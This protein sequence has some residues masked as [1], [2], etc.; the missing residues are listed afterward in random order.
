MSN[1]EKQLLEN[2]S[3]EVRF[4]EISR[5]V[6]SVDASIY[7]I[8]PIGIVL[9]KTESD[10]L[11]TIRIAKQHGIPIIARGA[12]T[13]ITGGCIG[14]GLIIDLSKYMN[15][16]LEINEE[17]GYAI[18]QPG[19]VQDRLNEALAPRGYRLGPDTSTGNRATLGGMAGNNAAGA[20]SLR[21]GK[22]VDHVQEVKLALASG[23]LITFGCLD[24][25]QWQQKAQ[26]QSEEGN[27]YRAL[28]H[29]R[30]EYAEDIRTRFPHIPRRVS[31]YNLDT[32]LHPDIIN[33]SQL[34]VG[35]EGSLGIISEMKVRICKRPIH[36]G[37]CLMHCHDMIQAMAAIPQMLSQNPLAIE[38]IDH[39]II[40]M[41]AQSPAMKGKLDW[42]MGRP[43]AIFAAEFEGETPQEV[44]EKLEQFKSMVEKAS[45]ADHIA[46]ITDSN[47]MNHVWDIRK[48]GLGLLL[49]KRDYSRAIAFVE[50]L[51]VAPEQLAPF[52]KEFN[53][54][55]AKINKS[56]GIYGH[57]GSGCMHLRP[58]IDL[59][60]PEE[61]A[62]MLRMMNEISDLVLKYGGALSGEH[63]DGHLR[64]WLN[65]KM[66]GKRLYQAFLE[67]KHAFDPADLM[68]PGKVVNGQAFL[69]NLRLSPD[70]VTTEFQTFQDFTPEGGFELAVD[71]CNGNGLC[72]KMEGTMCPSFQATGDEFHSTRARAQT[73]R[74]LIHGRLKMK[75]MAQQGIYDVLD[76]CLQCKA[77]KT[78]CPSQVDMAKMKAE[79]LF[80]YQEK[81]GYTLRNRIFAHIGTLNA[82]MSPFAKFF[83]HSMQ[84]SVVQWLFKKMGISTQHPLPALS[85]E[86]FSEWMSKI[87]LH[88]EGKKV[89]L[90]NDTYTE[91]YHPEIGQAAYRV[92]SA[93]GYQVIVPSWKCCGRTLISKGFLKQA[94]K[95]ALAVFNQLLPYVE[96]GIP[97]VGLEPSCIL[98]LKDDFKGLLPNHEIDKLIALTSTFDEFV[99]AHITD[100]KLPLA[101]KNIEAAVKVHGHCHQ[102]ALVGMAPTLEVLKSIATLKVEEIHSGCCGMAGSFGYEQEHEVIS[103]KIGELVLLPAVRATPKDTIIIANGMSCRS[104]IQHG[105]SRHALHVAQLLD[106]LRKVD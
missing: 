10:L 18:C 38:M 97:I 43:Q 75:E 64:T 47:L 41:G 50:D 48:A 16:I 87:P 12:A 80:H 15:R 71:L 54:Y 72:R 40:E 102:K 36:T 93:L 73:L 44:T 32:L 19:V 92:L 56:A 53:D 76:L 31:G 42:L 29:I 34:I 51:T 103:Q 7:E 13:G 46:L 99:H 98:T 84:W 60:K 94:K 45:F 61:T 30:T 86:R 74:D 81:Y 49:S 68:N 21:Y 55:L 22:M 69:D 33:V 83:N 3:G 63:G 28:M 95:K 25:H 27:I 14:K 26:E 91:F 37:I 57:V 11:N 9:P 52:M 6:Y 82:M 101:F 58:Y 89:V 85:P 20:R 100:G 17:R 2:I 23:N 4:D 96:E 35:A 70:T 77:C 5:K 67:V 90:F 79:F 88:L 105:T 106:I 104:Q 78:E 59:R 39:H 65:E 62:L 8:E 66:F 24:I 1:L